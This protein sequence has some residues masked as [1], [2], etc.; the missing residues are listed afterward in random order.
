MRAVITKNQTKNQRVKKK[1]KWRSVLI[2][3]ATSKRIN[4]SRTS[5]KKKGKLAVSGEVIITNGSER[6]CNDLEKTIKQKV[7]K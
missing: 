1:K 4:G 2:H 5:E 3:S 7:P 6:F